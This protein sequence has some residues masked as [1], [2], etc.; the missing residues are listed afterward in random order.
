VLVHRYEPSSKLD[1]C[2]LPGRMDSLTISNM[3]ANATILAI[4]LITTG[5]SQS[6]SQQ[7]YSV[8]IV[9]YVN[10]TIPAGKQAI[11]NNPLNGTNNNVN[12]IIPLPNN[13]GHAGSAIFRYNSAALSFLDPIEW[14]DDLGG[15]ALRMKIRRST[16]GKAFTFGMPT[17]T[18]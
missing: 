14:F 18:P 10:I 9:G 2:G 6:L 1:A 17:R 16:Q 13:V 3:K 12:T 15:S 7:V 4:A 8:N 5:A 11:L